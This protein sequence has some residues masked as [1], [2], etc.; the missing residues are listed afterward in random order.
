MNARAQASDL[1][2]PLVN[3]HQGVFM[4]KLIALLGLVGLFNIGCQPSHHEDP[5]PAP[6]SYVY[7]GFDGGDR[8]VNTLVLNNGQFEVRYY[9]F[10]SHERVG[11]YTKYSGT[12]SISGNVYTVTVNYDTC[13][14]HVPYT[15]SFALTPIDATTAS[16]QAYG[17][18]SSISVSTVAD[19]EGYLAS[20][21][22]RT[23][24]ENTECYN[25]KAFAAT[26]SLFKEFSKSAAQ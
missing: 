24:F 2:Y 11:I 26:K 18:A 19:I 25:M 13:E 12:Y 7:D 21:G 1:Q 17:S 6:V 15:D 5:L 3:L 10:D 16:L 8:I 23:S 14:T 20:T 4:K 22:M 9:Q